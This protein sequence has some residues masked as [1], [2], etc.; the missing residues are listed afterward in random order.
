MKRMLIALA[1]VTGLVLYMAY[2]DYWVARGIWRNEKSTFLTTENS[3]GLAGAATLAFPPTQVSGETHSKPIRDLAPTRYFVSTEYPA[4]TFSAQAAAIQAFWYLEDLGVKRVTLIGSSVGVKVV[5]AFIRY[6]ETQGEN[7]LEII[8]VV[9]VDPAWD[10]DSLADK[11][12][13]IPR[14]VWWPGAVAN[15]FSEGFWADG[16]NPPTPEPD[17]DKEAL[18]EHHRRSK[19]FKLSSWGDQVGTAAAPSD[20][21]RGEF[22]GILMMILRSKHDTVVEDA[23]IPLWLGAFGVDDSHVFYVESAHCDFPAYPKAWRA[24]FERA[25]AQLPPSCS[26]ITYEA[27]PEIWAG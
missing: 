9:L 18:A 27:R 20:V 16:F 21:K 2:G 1:V 4:H 10:A 22:A 13:W 19:T 12:T 5:A 7:A 3:I 24:V 23:A 25:F 11:R 15:V 6:N 26:R 14:F 8:G 17:V